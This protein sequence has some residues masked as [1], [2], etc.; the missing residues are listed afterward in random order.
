MFLEEIRKMKNICERCG[1]TLS[2]LENYGTDEHRLCY[3]CA[4]ESVEKEN[5]LEKPDRSPVNAKLPPENSGVHIATFMYETE[6][7][8]AILLLNANGIEAGMRDK[9]IVY[10]DPL[11]SNAVG[12][13]KLFVEKKD[14]EEAKRILDE[15]AKKRDEEIGNYCY[16]CESTEVMK[17]PKKPFWKL[18]VV[19]VITLGVG[20]PQV[21]KEYRC[22]KCGY[23]W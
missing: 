21:Y 10:T 5:P 1:K 14:A 3:A 4:N 22:K 18:L 13:I 9:G 20:L 15:D 17:I 6:A 7:E 8:S 12:G 23:K 11:I 2:S 19:A 16:K